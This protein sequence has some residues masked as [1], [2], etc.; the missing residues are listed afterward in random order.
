MTDAELAPLVGR[1]ARYVLQHAQRGVS[2][3]ELREQIRAYRKLHPADRFRLQVLLCKEPELAVVVA[4]SGT[5]YYYGRGQAPE[6][7]FNIEEAR[8]QRQ[9]EALGRAMQWT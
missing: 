9:G 8:R 4:P 5:L 6:G 7:A 2:H 1:C 3:L